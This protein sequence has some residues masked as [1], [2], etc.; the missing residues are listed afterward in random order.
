MAFTFC[1]C[2]GKA[3][4]TDDFPAESY[5][6]FWIDLKKLLLFCSSCSF[7][8]GRM[9][10]SQRRGVI[11]LIPKKNAIP[12]FLK[13]GR[14]ISL[15]NTDYKIATQCIAYS[16]KHVLPSVIHSDQTGYSKERYIGENVRL[17]FDIIEQTSEYEIPGLIF[18][19]D[20][21]KAFDSIGHTVLFNFKFG[22]VLQRWIEVFCKDI[23][24][25][26]ITVHLFQ[27]L[28]KCPA[29]MPPLPLSFYNLH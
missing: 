3:P 20:F 10:I 7:K 26:V 16:L 11:T 24:S 23:S 19:A 22:K 8:T 13:N 2:N 4:G 18:F 27:Y 9:S 12:F 1:N 25:S 28:S 6:V 5:K 21:E 29:R 15:L 17:L 14:R